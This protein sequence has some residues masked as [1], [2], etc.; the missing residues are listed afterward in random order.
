MLQTSTVVPGNT[1][2]PL[3]E[4]ASISDAIYVLNKDIPVNEYGLPLYFLRSDL[5][6]PS[7]AC[8]TQDAVDQAACGLFYPDGYPVLENGGTYWNQL[9]HEPYNAY[10]QFQKYLDMVEDHGIRQ[11]DLLAAAEHEDLLNYQAL[12]REYYWSSRA[13]AYD[14]FIT[15]AEQKK[16]EHRIRKMENTHFEKTRALMEKLL[17]RFDDPDWIEELSAKEALEGLETLIK[18]QRLSVGLTGQHASSNAGNNI[19][20]GAS[21]E[22]IVRQI[23]KNASDVGGANTDRFQNKLLDLLNDPTQGMAVQ[24]MVLRV[25]AHEGQYQA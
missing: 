9:P 19:P 12:Y 5:L 11:L 1:I 15:A 3:P 7:M 25:N 17:A 14:L 16:R 13:R 20:K 10:M 21:A 4:G 6:A 18:L 23:T 8:L 24:E 22:F 2:I